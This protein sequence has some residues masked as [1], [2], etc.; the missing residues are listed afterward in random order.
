MVHA[1]IPL[2]HQ[3]GARGAAQGGDGHLA[4]PGARP[5]AAGGVAGRAAH[6]PPAAHPRRP[7]GQP[8]GDRLLLRRGHALQP[9][10]AA[11]RRP[12]R[13]PGSRRLFLRGVLGHYP[14]H[15]DS[16]RSPLITGKIHSGATSRR[17]RAGC[18]MSLHPTTTRAE[19]EALAEAVRAGVKN[20]GTWEADYPNLAP[21]RVHPRARRHR[22]SGPRAAL[23]DLDVGVTQVLMLPGFGGGADQPVLV[24][25]ERALG[26]HGLGRDPC[27][28]DADAPRRGS[29][30]RWR[31]P[32]RGW[33]PFVDLRL[34][35]AGRSGAGCSARLALETSP[36]A[37]V[38]LGFPVPL[39]LLVGLASARGRALARG[40]S[41]AHADGPGRGRPA[42]PGADAGAARGEERAA[43]ADRPRGRDPFL[44]F[45]G[46][47]EAVESP[48]RARSGPG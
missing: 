34:M 5:R 47:P 13:H 46:Q 38:L 22:R 42:G 20:A 32:G 43:G 41:P 48:R 39:L 10:G 7:P 44:E 16:N 26:T 12:V 35:P 18:G 36:R 8:A 2:D 14:L 45:A 4:D 19:V 31:K 28:A 15:V 9:D 1:G 37:L 30:G 11:P 27:R 17:S 40:V 21:P 3:G 25:L 23:P 33:T 29:P 6:R 24:A